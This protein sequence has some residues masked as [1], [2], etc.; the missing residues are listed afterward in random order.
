MSADLYADTSAGWS[1]EEELTIAAIQQ[2]E[3]VPRPEAIRRMQRRKHSPERFR[4]SPIIRPK[5]RLGNAVLTEARSCDLLRTDGVYLTRACDQCG[6]L[7]HYANRFTRKD[8]PGVWCSRECRDGK[9][10]Y[11]PGICKGCGAALVGKRKGATYCGRTCRMRTARKHGQD[12]QIIVNTRIQNKPLAE[13][14]FASGYIPTSHG[15]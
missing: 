14:I 3:S 4:F 11:A 15:A 1:T 8:D 6:T 13:P 2:A 12:S 7:I 9:E 5:G 10:A